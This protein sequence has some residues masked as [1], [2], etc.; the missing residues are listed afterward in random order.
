MATTS[1][2]RAT[3]DF[4]SPAGH[5]DDAAI[6]VTQRAIGDLTELS[7]GLAKENARLMAEVQTTAIDALRESQAAVMRWQA[8]WP[9]ALTDPMG[10]Y[11]RTCVETIDTTRRALALMGSNSRLVVQSIDRLQ[12][13]ATDAERRLRDTLTSAPGMR[14]PARRG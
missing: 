13:A 10:A 8:L 2:E 7:I 3:R 5:A 9:Q 14:E 11:Q 12:S 4:E 6:G 1:Q